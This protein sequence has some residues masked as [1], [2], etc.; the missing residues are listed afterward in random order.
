MFLDPAVGFRIEVVNAKLVAALT[1]I[2]RMCNII[3]ACVHIHHHPSHT[4]RC[5]FTCLNRETVS[6]R[7]VR[8]TR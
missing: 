2:E 7:A 1:L 3:P 8:A 5:L 6:I 4:P